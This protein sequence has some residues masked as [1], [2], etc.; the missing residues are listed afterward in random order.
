MRL[1]GTPR[2]DAACAAQ[3]VVRFGMI[4]IG[5][6]GGEH[7]SIGPISRVGHA[8]WFQAKVT[9]EVNGFMGNIDPYFEVSDISR[10][11]EQ[12]VQLYKVLKGAAELTTTEGQFGLTVTG[13]GKGHLEVNGTA[14]RHASYGTCLKFEF[15]LDQTF[16][17]TLI[18]SLKLVVEGHA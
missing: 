17:P 7:V 5:N 1:C 12:L 3:L 13:D 2:R 9:I 14:Y 10:F 11:H 15:M 16:L 8:E 6:Q 18:R 4:V